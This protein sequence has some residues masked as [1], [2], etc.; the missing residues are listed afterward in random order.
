MSK[1]SILFLFL[2]ITSGCAVF[3]P[4]DRPITNFLDDH[5]APK[6]ETAQTLLM[7]IALPVGFVSLV[8]DAVIVNPFK[9]IPDAVNIAEKPFTEID[10][11]PS[12]EIIV[13]PM[14]IV[15]SFV[16]FVGAEITHC[17]F[18]IPSSK[19]SPPQGEESN[20]P[21]QIESDEIQD[22]NLEISE[23]KEGN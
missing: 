17:L 14:R 1:I 11:Y 7:P 19:D 6:N 20:D 2:G 16:M 9:Q 12:V 8:A 10:Y 15:T 3:H 18:P 5:L 23:E 4:P 21:N 22:L 13:F